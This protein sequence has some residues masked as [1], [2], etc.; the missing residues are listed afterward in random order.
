MALY[1][2][3]LSMLTA[4]ILF[5]GTAFA[6]SH[7]VQVPDSI[8]IYHEKMVIA[9]NGDAEVHVH[10]QIGASEPGRYIVPLNASRPQNL[11]M[12]S[13]PEIGV[14]V[15]REHGIRFIALDIQEVDQPVTDV[16]RVKY[17]LPGYYVF[18]EQRKDALGRIRFSYR[19]TNSVNPALNEYKFTVLFAQPYNIHFI[20]ATRNIVRGRSSDF[21]AIDIYR[22]KDTGMNGFTVTKEDM[23]FG[24]PSSIRAEIKDHS[25]SFLFLLAMLVFAGWGFWYYRG[26]LEETD[27]EKQ[28]VKGLE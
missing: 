1:K 26:H 20:G 4:V 17:T 21:D 13:H 2:Y 23:R 24:R 14:K 3:F 12:V 19:F 25:P 9:E 28:L 8:M 18:D 22:D 16:L 10:V 6:G 11:Q 7:S 15:H 27:E 5:S